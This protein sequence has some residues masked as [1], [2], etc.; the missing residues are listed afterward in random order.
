MF[1][2]HALQNADSD[3]E[4]LLADALG[5]ESLGTGTH[6][7]RDRNGDR[8]GAIDVTAI[9]RLHIEPSFSPSGLLCVATAPRVEWGKSKAPGW[10]KAV[11]C[12]KGDLATVKLESDPLPGLLSGVQ[13]L[14]ES[15]H[16]YR[17]GTHYRLSTQTGRIRGT[18]E[19]NNPDS[20]D[21]IALE[22]ECWQLAENIA[23]A[24]GLLNLHRFTSVWKQSIQERG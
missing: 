13:W 18:V 22:A 4:D 19:F 9:W 23:C 17:D 24:S 3:G 12:C 5:L 21:L 10:V 20:S 8:V 15:A 14:A 1:T 7:V 6:R 2:V 11:L 16:Q